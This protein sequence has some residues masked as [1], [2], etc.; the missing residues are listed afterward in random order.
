[1]KFSLVFG[2]FGLSS[3]LATETVVPSEQFH[4]VESTFD[5]PGTEDTLD[6]ITVLQEEGASYT[7]VLVMLH[8]MRD[9]NT[10]AADR[11]TDYNYYGD[12]IEGLKVIFP[13]SIFKEHPRLS[14]VYNYYYDALYDEL[15]VG[16]LFGTP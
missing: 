6:I 1:M 12:S 16:R 15:A 7:K 11:L 8:G 4:R 3:V 2:A 14:L 5:V 9:G 13:A 10:R